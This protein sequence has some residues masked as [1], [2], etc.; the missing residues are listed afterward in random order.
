MFTGI[1]EAIGTI[2][3]KQDIG[4]DVRLRIV[5]AVLDMSDVS[6]GDS[7]ATNG[8]CLTVVEINADGFWADVSNET[9]R[10]SSLNDLSEGAA[11]NLEKAMLA[12]SRF[13]GHI[14]SGHVD[15]VGEV[16]GLNNDGRSVQIEIASP[17]SLSKYIAHKGSI[18][19][20]GVSLTVNE[21]TA[22]GFLLNIVPHTVSETIIADYQV[23]SR[24]NLEVDV[25]ARYLEQ[26]LKPEQAQPKSAL[27]KE[28]LAA[29][30]FYK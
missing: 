19:I 1:I 28:F 21:L 29:N 6:L 22:R 27:S 10:H 9:I 20:D 15:G 17:A 14:V 8:V 12:S 4:G 13:G 23:G 3:A 5:S 2:G 24:I 18:T 30:G 11:V 25:I 26:L 16:L 7:I